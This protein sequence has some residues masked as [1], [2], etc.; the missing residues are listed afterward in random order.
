M[1]L[2][3]FHYPSC[4][5]AFLC[6]FRS[7]HSS[8]YFFHLF[9]NL[10]VFIIPCVFSSLPLPGFR[11][12][13]QCSYFFLPSLFPPCFSAS[14]L[15][16]FFI[17]PCSSSFLSFRV[18]FFE[19]NFHDA[20]ELITRSRNSMKCLMLWCLQISSLLCSHNCCRL[21]GRRTRQ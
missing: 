10:N 4:F 15:F 18:H 13:P 7:F 1:L 9:C 6:L 14:S 11:S 21:F 3:S 2:S 8:S 19:G 17:L 5:S 12:F 16:F 20:E